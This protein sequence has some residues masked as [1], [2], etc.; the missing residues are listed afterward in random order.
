MFVCIEHHDSLAIIDR[1]RAS[2]LIQFL[3]TQLIFLIPGVVYL[4][5]RTGTPPK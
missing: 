2:S 3:P 1:L 5:I 4:P